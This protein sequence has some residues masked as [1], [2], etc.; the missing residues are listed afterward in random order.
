[1][2][3]AHD[4]GTRKH[5]VWTAAGGVQEL[6][7]SAA[8]LGTDGH[9]LVWLEGRRD[10]A[11]ERFTDIRVVTAPFTTD[12]A[13]LRPRV[14]RGE[15]SAHLFGTS[16]FVVGCG[17]AARAMFDGAGRHAVEVIRLADGATWQLPDVPASVWGYRAP[18]A[19]SCDELFAR[20]Y[21]RPAAGQPGHVN[22]AR[23]R[24]EG[25][26]APTALPHR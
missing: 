16:A 10:P 6:L 23:V 13:R 1:M 15:A 14:V 21:E 9:D 17:H 12:P 20:V 25:L 11:G 4:D 5:M 7:S 8:D 26:G 3:A 24:L 2:W 18:L 19:L 22:V